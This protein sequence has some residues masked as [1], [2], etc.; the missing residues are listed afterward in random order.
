MNLNRPLE[1]L[2][3]FMLDECLP[4]A[5]RDRRIFMWLPFRIVFGSKARYFLDFKKN[6]ARYQDSFL[7][8]AYEKT[9]S[10]SIQDEGTDLSGSMIDLIRENISGDAV[11]DAGCGKGSLARLLSLEHSVTACDII[12]DEEL[13]TNCPGVTFREG[14]VES[15]PFEDDEFDTVTCTHT[16]EHVW[17]IRRA[18]EE[19]RRVASRR[20]IVVVPRERP[21]RYAFNLHLHYFLFEYQLRQ[22]FE[23]RDRG[24]ACIIRMLDG[25]W[26]YH[27][28]MVGPEAGTT[29]SY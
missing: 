21:Y 20:L 12:I 17:D 18:V 22:L 13:M 16:L 9:S 25:C 27:E 11:L 28:D 23:G 29:A 3:R 2:I 4:P 26:Y 5:I 24:A 14:N 7:K 8:E 10:V 1:R 6:A 15:L 19:L